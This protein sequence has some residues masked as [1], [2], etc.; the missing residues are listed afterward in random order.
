MPAPTNCGREEAIEPVLEQARLV[1]DHPDL[2]PTAR[3]SWSSARPSLRST[4]IESAWWS[5]IAVRPAGV[6]A[7]GVTPLNVPDLVLGAFGLLEDAPHTSR[8]SVDRLVVARGTWRVPA[9]ELAFAAEL[10]EARRFVEARAWLR[11]ASLPERMFAGSPLEQKPFF[12]DFQSPAYANELAKAVRSIQADEQI[13]TI[14]LVELL[15]NLERLWLENA[16]GARY[17]SELRLAA[18]GLGP[19]PEDSP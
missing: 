6:A 4:P 12:V 1:L 8:I 9:T 19:T 2:S 16:D 15:P 14:R 11:R 3:R 17:T 5:Q 13:T 7:D 18:F 10:D